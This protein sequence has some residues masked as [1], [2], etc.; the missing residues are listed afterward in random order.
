[1]AT[2]KKAAK[3]APKMDRKLVAAKQPWEVGYEAKKLGITRTELRAIV[4]AVG[5]SR[6]KI[7]A[8]AE[9]LVA[10]KS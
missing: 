10:E 6:A 3:K 8:A 1:M 5:H 4:A 9:R 2:A 7:E